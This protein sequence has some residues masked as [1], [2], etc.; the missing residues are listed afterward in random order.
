VNGSSTT[1][2]TSL[3]RVGYL[4][5]SGK[6]E[7]HRRQASPP[8]RN[9]GWAVSDVNGHGVQCDRQPHRVR[10]RQC[11]AGQAHRRPRQTT[12]RTRFA[13]TV[14]VNSGSTLSSENDIL[15]GFAGNNNLGK[16]V[17]N[18]GTVNLATATKRWLI[19]SQWDTS[20]S[21]SRRQQRPS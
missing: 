18:G 12:T 7:H 16:L 17:V 5:G 9:S 10:R 8:P 6:P 3:S 2:G 20:Q 21:E 14:T 11:L 19:M 1:L 13:G 4:A 15:L